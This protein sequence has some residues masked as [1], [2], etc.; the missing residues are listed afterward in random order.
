MQIFTFASNA[1]FEFCDLPNIGG[2]TEDQNFKRIDF[3]RNGIYCSQVASYCDSTDVAILSRVESQKKTT[4]RG[5][6]GTKIS[7][8]ENEASE[9]APSSS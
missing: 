8:H 5:E 4:C 9:N 7:D 2:P 6:N 1:K 3:D